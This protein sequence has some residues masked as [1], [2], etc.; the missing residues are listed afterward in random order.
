[1]L[2]LVFIVLYCVVNCIYIELIDKKDLFINFVPFSTPKD[3]FSSPLARSRLLFVW[4]CSCSPAGG[5]CSLLWW[6]G[7]AAWGRR[8]GALTARECNEGTGDRP[9][10]KISE[11][12]TSL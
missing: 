2:L 9:E 8:R 4:L 10:G 3:A 11:K 12:K 1:M 7:G 6:G 5:W